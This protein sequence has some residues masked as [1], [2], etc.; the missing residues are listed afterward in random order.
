MV[1]ILTKNGS[2]IKDWSKF[3]TT[4]IIKSP[5]GE[6]EIHFYKN[7]LTKEIQYDIDFK[8]IL[9]GN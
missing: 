9:I 5:A 1:E 4:G 3:T 6:I 2:D 7:K 8:T